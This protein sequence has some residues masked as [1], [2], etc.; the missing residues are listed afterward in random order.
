MASAEPELLEV[1][2]APFQILGESVGTVWIIAHDEV[3]K[4]DSEDARVVESV[5]SV[6]A[7]AFTMRDAL[8]RTMELNEELKRSNARLNRVLERQEQPHSESAKSG[9]GD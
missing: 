5:A 9:E 1:L 6:A 3:R 4:F 7:V 2:L 8:S